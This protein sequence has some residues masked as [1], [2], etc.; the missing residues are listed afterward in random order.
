VAGTELKR[1]ESLLAV[2]AVSIREVELARQEMESAQSELESAESSLRM[3]GAPADS[4]DGRYELRSPIVGTVVRRPAIVGTFATDET[5]LA[6][7][8]DT[9]VMWALLDIGEHEADLVTVGVPVTVY[10]EAGAAQELEGTITWVSSEV[11]LRTRTVSARAEVRN[12]F[13]LLRANQ[14]VRAIVHVE[15]SEG[16]LAVPRASVQRF[17]EEAVVFVRTGEGQYEPRIVTLERSTG[18]L[19]QISGD[20]RAGD[21]VVTDGAYLLKTELSKDS[22]GAGCCDVGTKTAER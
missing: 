1:Q 6:T 4:R 8:A 15:P 18:D 3:T 10:V 17:G 2:Q 9:R 21:A 14:F 5:S 13:G 12:S 11:D 20:V 16:A 7:I 22:I 19:V